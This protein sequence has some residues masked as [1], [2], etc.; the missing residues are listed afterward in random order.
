MAKK[1]YNIN[2]EFVYSFDNRKTENIT[3]SVVFS[4][5]T[6]LLLISGNITGEAVELSIIKI[7]KIFYQIL[8]FLL[9]FGLI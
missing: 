6:D 8:W 4:Y 2:A 7:K 1:E 3:K 9:I 5:L